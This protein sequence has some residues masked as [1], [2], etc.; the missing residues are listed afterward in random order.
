MHYVLAIII[1]AA[2]VLIAIPHVW[3]AV[4]NVL[5]RLRSNDTDNDHI[6]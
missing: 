5:D 1:L 6:E 2:L 4:A 3:N